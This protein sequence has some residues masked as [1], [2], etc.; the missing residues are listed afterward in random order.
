MNT[1]SRIYGA[2]ASPQLRICEIH[3]FI[4][5]WRKRLFIAAGMAYLE[6]KCYSSDNACC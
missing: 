4:C 3:L 6:L 2:R 5:R 1:E